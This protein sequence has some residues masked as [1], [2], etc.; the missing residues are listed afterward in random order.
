MPIL[1]GIRLYVEPETDDAA[2]LERVRASLQAE[3]ASAE[4]GRRTRS[5][6]WR[7]ERCW[8]SGLA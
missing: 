6:S 3:L 1:D 5:P 2:A 8:T 7:A 4:P